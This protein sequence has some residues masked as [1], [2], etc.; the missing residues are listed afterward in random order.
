MRRS[1]LV[2]VT[3]VLVA[4]VL[5]LVLPTP[6]LALPP[7]TSLRPEMRPDGRVANLPR[8]VTVST[9]ASALAVPRSIRPQLRGTLVSA[10]QTAPVVAAPMA[11]ATA[12]S[13]VADGDFADWLR[14][15][16]TRARAA[17]ISA[18]T[19][20]QA[21]SGV[22]VLP[23]VLERDR[24]QAEFSRA[25]WEYLDSAVS[26]TRVA[27]G[28]S[29]FD[30]HRD[31]LA[32]IER[33]YG[34]EAEVVVAIWGLES[35]YGAMRGD[36]DIIAAMATL[37]YDGRRR[38]FFEE[39]LIA[40]LRILQA[41]DVAPR[42]MT[43]SWAGAMGHTQFMPNSYLEHA[44]DFDGNGRRN[45]WSDDPVDA[46]ASTANYLRHHG[47]T[48]GQPWGLEVVLPQGF[49]F[50]LTGEQVK[51]PASFWND[52]GIRL[53]GGG[54]IPDH[55]D[56]SILL[57]AGHRGV[58]LVIFD[59]FHVIER[60][61]P[62]DAYVIAVGHLSDRIGGAGPFRGS[63]PRED[64]ALTRAEREELQQRLTRA[65]FHSHGVD[66]IIGPQ[67]ID[68]VRRFQASVG[69]VPDGYASLRVLEQLR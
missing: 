66:G 47:W 38:A 54:T 53:A 49:D 32:R 9:Q 1:R 42:Q 24:N 11:P 33:R 62:A 2:L 40:A 23:R 55:G 25:L 50:S 35:A 5:G 59:N 56:A 12:P 22:S 7:A 29:A 34:V 44:V 58:A 27:N 41:G 31:T 30:R 13:P 51:R 61:N 36:T 39:Q 15:F 17:G 21:F 28:R 26:D 8:V 68:S 45:I 6:A 16:R 43:G 14:S 48:T 10:R 19:L 37:A 46:L 3:G 57:P 20:D 63:W 67:T 69:S 4:G 64:R 52:R 18:A 65:G 60:Y